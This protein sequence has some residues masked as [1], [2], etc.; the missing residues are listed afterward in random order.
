MCCTCALSVDGC[1]SL[2]STRNQ[3]ARPTSKM[4]MRS[5][6]S[7]FYLLL[8]TGCCCSNGS[9]LF[10]FFF[11]SFRLS[12]KILSLLFCSAQVPVRNL[13]TSSEMKKRK[14]KKRNA[15]LKSFLVCRGRWALGTFGWKKAGGGKSETGYSV[16]NR[17]FCVVHKGKGKK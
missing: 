9:G 3:N 15:E 1:L 8:K 13:K 11:P 7:H 10:F 12:L 5:L 17:G 2:I 14:K 6:N 16:Q 4:E